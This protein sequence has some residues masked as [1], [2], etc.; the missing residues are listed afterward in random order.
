MAYRKYFSEEERLIARRKVPE[1]RG[2]VR[3]LQ[4]SDFKNTKRNDLIKEV[5]IMIVWNKEKNTRLIYLDKNG[6]ET[7]KETAD[8]FLMQE[9]D[10]NGKI[11]RETV[12][13]LKRDEV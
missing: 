2:E 3:Y 11:I 7:N 8:S 12:G 13:K 5:R 1:V 4:S 6:D 10:K 9:F